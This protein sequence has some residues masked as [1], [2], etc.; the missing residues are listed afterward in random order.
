M[1][2]FKLVSQ[3]H[4]W[5]LYR[6]RANGKHER[7]NVSTVTDDGDYIVESTEPL[8]PPAQLI[9]R[10]PRVGGITTHRYAIG[11]ADV[12]IE[13]LPAEPVLVTPEPV[14]DLDQVIFALE[15]AEKQLQEHADR[16][17]DGH[18]YS[19]Q[20]PAADAERMREAIDFINANR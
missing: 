6:Q 9:S 5:A 16:L 14:V 20:F 2:A 1:K 17:R 8:G 3:G 12:E 13:R 11:R 18:D 4:R 15:R 19:A 10:Q 7:L